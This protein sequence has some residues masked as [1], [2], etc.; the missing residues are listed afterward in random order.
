MKNILTIAVCVLT[1]LLVFLAY[2]IDQVTKDYQTYYHLYKVQKQVLVFLATA[3]ESKYIDLINSV[4]A[5]D[6]DHLTV[7]LVL[8]SPG[9]L[10]STSPG[11]DK[12][13]EKNK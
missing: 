7:D 9:K 11:I 1:I 10:V 3:K 6:K 13:T 12:V 8:A 2:Q 5:E 4:L